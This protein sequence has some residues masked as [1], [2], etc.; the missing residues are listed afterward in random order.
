MNIF[1][2][3]II[4]IILSV[5]TLLNNVNSNNKPDERAMIEKMVISYG[6]YQNEADNKVCDLLIALKKKNAVS[7]ERWAKIMR[8]WRAGLRLP[9]NY[10]VLPDG[11]TDTDELCIVVLGFELEDD[12]KMRTELVKR[13]E[14]ALS[15]ANKYK[16]AY[17]VCSGGGTAHDDPKITEAGE[18]KKWLVDKGVSEKRIIVEDKS[19]STAQNAMFTCDILTKEYPRVKK[20]A[21]VSSDYHIEPSILFFYAVSILNQNSLTVVSNAAWKAPKHILTQLFRAGGLMEIAG[22]E[23]TAKAVYNRT[24][25]FESVSPF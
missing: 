1:I 17:I 16:N 13:L 6:Y 8:L 25:D 9:V 7:G 11:L 4:I 3:I 23:D 14:V 22:Y 2:K 24:Y 18:M 12:G 5:L 20:L 21:V 19:V 15:C 10:D